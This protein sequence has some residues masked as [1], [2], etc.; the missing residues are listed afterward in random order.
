MYSGIVS[1][2]CT[3]KTYYTGRGGAVTAARC[4]RSACRGR[5]T[6]R[7][8]AGA[9][10]RAPA[11]SAP[12]SAAAARRTAPWAAT[13][14]PTPATGTGSWYRAH[15]PLRRCTF[16]PRR[17]SYQQRAE[18]REDGAEAAEGGAG[19]EQAVARARREQ[20]RAV[21]VERVQGHSR[22]RLARQV[23]RSARRA[24]THS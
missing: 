14:A 12:R 22:A 2:T 9:A 19:G 4:R 18:R 5:R 3:T 8:A 21:H 7:A 24:A 13:T 20:L 16:C 11:A 1:A 10:Y 6:S 17:S 15:V 23:Q